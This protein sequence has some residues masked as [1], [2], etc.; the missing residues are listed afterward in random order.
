MCVKQMQRT[1]QLTIRTHG[2]CE[3]CSKQTTALT[4]LWSEVRERAHPTS[5]TWYCDNAAKIAKSS[6]TRLSTTYFD[7][8]PFAAVLLDMRKLRLEN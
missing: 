3:E 5:F 1:Q 2:D 4:K 6:S 8:V 7:S